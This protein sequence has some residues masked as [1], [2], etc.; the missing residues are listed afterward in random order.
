MFGSEKKNNLSKQL[1]LIRQ[2]ESDVDFQKK[3]AIEALEKKKKIYKS[4]SL[5][6]GLETGYKDK[7][8]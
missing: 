6:N 1:T 4:N 7:L 2:R 5:L 8:G 3:Q